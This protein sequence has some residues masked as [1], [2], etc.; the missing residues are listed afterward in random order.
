MRYMWHVRQKGFLYTSNYGQRRQ[1][2]DCY[3]LQISGL[4]KATVDCAI[5]LVNLMDSS[6][7]TRL[8]YCF[9][10]AEK[11]FPDEMLIFVT[12]FIKKCQ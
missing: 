1:L 10:F 11:V 3:D 4:L 5:T 6:T 9:V 12:K 8:N 2:M 7:L